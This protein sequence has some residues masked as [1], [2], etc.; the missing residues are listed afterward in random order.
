MLGGPGIPYE[1][2]FVDIGKGEQSAPAFLAVPP[3][4]GIPALVDDDA[5]GGSLP[6]LQGRDP[7]LLADED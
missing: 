2:A 5:R 1:V 3:K 6:I 7:A 4:V